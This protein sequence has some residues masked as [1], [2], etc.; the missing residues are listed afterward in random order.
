MILVAGLEG[1]EAKLSNG[2]EGK[3]G[4]LKTHFN[5]SMKSIDIKLLKMNESLHNDL[6]K[7]VKGLKEQKAKSEEL[8]ADFKEFRKS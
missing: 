7:A 2:W 1:S 3:L 6:D 4:A 5:R 8:Q